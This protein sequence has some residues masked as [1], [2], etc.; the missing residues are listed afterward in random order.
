MDILVPVSLV[1]FNIISKALH[2]IAIDPFDSLVSL[3][4]VVGSKMVPHLQQGA[5]SVQELRYDLRTI[6]RKDQT[7]RAVEV[8]PI[9]L[10]TGLRRP[11]R[12]WSEA[13]CCALAS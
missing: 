4:V 1:F 7:R 8:I 3:G 11:K 2:E 9:C 12:K 5:Y 13:G 6:V 10:S